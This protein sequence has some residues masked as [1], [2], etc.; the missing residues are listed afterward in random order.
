MDY[1]KIVRDTLKN[2]GF[3]ELNGAYMVAFK[4]HEKIVP[5]GTFTADILE[6]YKKDVARRPIGTW[7]NKKNGMVYLDTSIPFD[8]KK[9]ALKFASD[10]QHLA[11]YD[12]KNDE[13]I[14]L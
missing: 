6:K 11:I 1:K 3:S 2:G 13:T 8:N 12:T 5:H 14:Y 7:Y 9:E 10:N 4:E